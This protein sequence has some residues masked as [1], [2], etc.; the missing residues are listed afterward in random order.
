MLGK[1]QA[2]CHFS[3]L[4][5]FCCCNGWEE[6]G[7]RVADSLLA[8]LQQQQ[9]QPNHSLILKEKNPIAICASP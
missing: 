1:L 6:N 7:C 9:Q 5:L 8:S 3:I 4:S 2:H